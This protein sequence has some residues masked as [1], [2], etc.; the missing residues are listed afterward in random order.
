MAVGQAYT[1]FSAVVSTAIVG[2]LGTAQL[3]GVGLA[4]AFVNTLSSVFVFLQILV[5]PAVAKTAA[6]NNAE[7]LSTTI[8]NALWVAAIVGML[9][10]IFSFV[11]AE[12]IVAV[13]K[14]T[15][16][17]GKYAA[18]YIRCLA[19]F[20]PASLCFQTL[21]GVFRGLKET[22]ALFWGSVCVAATNVAMDLLFVYGFHWGVAGAG[23]ATVLSTWGGFLFLLA[24]LLSRRQLLPQHDTSLP[25]LPSVLKLLRKGIPLSLSSMVTLGMVFYASLSVSRLSVTSYAAFEITRLVFLVAFQLAYKPL[26][27]TAQ[28]LCASYL[29]KGDVH[30]AR[31]VYQRILQLAIMLSMVVGV[32]CLANTSRIGRLFTNDVAVVAEFYKPALLVFAFL[33]L[34]SMA[35]IADGALV[36]AQESDLVG[37]ANIASALLGLGVL[38]AT[39]NTGGL[40]LLKSWLCIKLAFMGRLVFTAHKLYFSRSDPYAVEEKGCGLE[41]EA[42]S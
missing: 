31:N 32:I 12:A 8:A 15:E 14:P 37:Y 4:S 27:F 2:R 23:A 33:P 11:G 13:M 9:I 16:G 34:E 10:S 5:T 18:L 3:G 7:E 40:T 20:G 35:S 22:R 1:S 21:G 36:A 24:T 41:G 30:N 42:G 39:V 25:S 17:V 19:F 29:G 28:T 26:E 6:Q 38:A